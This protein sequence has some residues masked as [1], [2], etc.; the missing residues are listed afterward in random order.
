MPALWPVG[1]RVPLVAQRD[2]KVRAAGFAHHQAPELPLFAPEKRLRQRSARTMPST[3]LEVLMSTLAVAHETS[4]ADGS[5]SAPNRPSTIRT[6]DLVVHL[7]TRDV[8][9][10]NQP[11][12]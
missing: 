4:T 10:N 7:S 8:S 6:G 2:A 5:S 12:R 3:D 1:R 9:V 11:V